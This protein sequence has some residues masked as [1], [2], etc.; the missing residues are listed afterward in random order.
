[1]SRV[2]ERIA[3]PIAFGADAITNGPVAQLVEPVKEKAKLFPGES[4][5]R[6]RRGLDLFA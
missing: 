4:P 6:G 1:M 3:V 2:Q 5:S